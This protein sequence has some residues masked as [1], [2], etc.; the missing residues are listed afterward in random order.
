MTYFKYPHQKRTVDRAYPITRTPAEV[1]D[2]THPLWQ[3]FLD[4]HMGRLDEDKEKRENAKSLL[5]SIHHGNY[6]TRRAF[7]LIA[8][9]KKEGKK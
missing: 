3:T 7:H 5:L 9:M 1:F 2:H 4:F 8:Q 6:N